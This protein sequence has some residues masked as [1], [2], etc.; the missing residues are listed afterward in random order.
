MPGVHVVSAFARDF[1]N[2][3][4]DL[5]ARVK[6]ALTNFPGDLLFIHRDAE[7]QSPELRLSEIHDVMQDLNVVFVPVIP[8]RMT[9]SWLLADEQAIRFAAG[10]AS[11]RIHLG[12]PGKRRWETLHDPKAVLLEALKV[13]S[14]R[15]GRALDKFNPEK[16]RHLIAPR[17][18][19][20]QM[21]RGL[22][23]FDA[24]EAEFI[25]QLRKLNYAL[26]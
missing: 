23:A 21:L 13:A 2:V 6:A 18:V 19:S 1:G 26:D 15:R 9:E 14:E 4:H 7:T 24:L 5:R 16:A 10:N 8:I 12:L 17:T 20:F 25:N 3:G 11:G 22:T